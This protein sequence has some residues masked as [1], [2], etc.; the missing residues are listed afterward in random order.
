MANRPKFNQGVL[1]K[2]GK[3]IEDL[4]AAGEAMGCD[5]VSWG[6]CP[7]PHFRVQSLCKDPDKD[8]YIYNEDGAFVTADYET[9]KAACDAVK[10]SK[11]PCA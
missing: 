8:I 4:I 5:C 10:K 6:C 1:G 7:C 9:F 11:T 3:N 2:N